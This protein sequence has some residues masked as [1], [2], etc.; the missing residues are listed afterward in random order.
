MSLPTPAKSESP[1]PT[2]PQ[3]SLP[4][5]S[6]FLGPILIRGWKKV[7]PEDAARF[8]DAWGRQPPIAATEDKAEAAAD[9]GAAAIEEAI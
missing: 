4:K 5:S 6:D 1:D 2:P 3:S 7:S 8:T 9:Q